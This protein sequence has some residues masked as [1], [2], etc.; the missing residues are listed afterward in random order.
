MTN[1]S[2]TI[3]YHHYINMSL[4]LLL[5]VIQKQLISLGPTLIDD[6]TELSL[7]SCFPALHG[8][9]LPSDGLTRITESLY[10]L[11]YRYLSIDIN[12]YIYI[13]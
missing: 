11:Y 10:P 7:D 8:A 12:I 13:I 3:I 6:T 5:D 9:L 4:L 2:S 1:I